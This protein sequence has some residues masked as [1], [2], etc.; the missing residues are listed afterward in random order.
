MPDIQF[1]FSNSGEM[2]LLA[3]A[4]G[5]SVGIDVEQLRPVPDAM[6][7][8]ADWLSAS[9]RAV[10]DAAPA[11]QRDALFC[12]CWTRREACIKAVGGDLSHAVDSRDIALASGDRS[13]SSTAA[14]WTMLALAPAPGY[15]GALVAEGRDWTCRQFAWRGEGVD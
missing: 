1:N 7:L 14:R 8:A 2:G 10:L 15:V 11:A 13:G 4:A 5:R 9:E 12:C 6:Q 3:V